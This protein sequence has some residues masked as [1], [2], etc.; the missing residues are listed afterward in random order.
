MYGIVLYIVYKL[1]IPCVF[2][3]ASSIYE[4]F[5]RDPIKYELYERATAA[6]LVDRL[7]SIKTKNPSFD[8]AVT[9]LYGI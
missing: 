6:A 9:P 7:S 2:V 4:T 8:N 3:L 5:E 1:N